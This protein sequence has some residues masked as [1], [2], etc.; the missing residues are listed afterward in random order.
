V[1][2]SDRERAD[3][4]LRAPVRLNDLG[5]VFDDTVASSAEVHVE[6]RNFYP[7]ML[8][9]ISSATSS[10]HINQFGF[11]PGSI[12]DQF[13]EVLSSKASDGIPVR[14]VVDRQGS[15]P[16]RGSRAFYERLLAAGIDVRVVRATQLRAPVQPVVVG[17]PTRWNFDRLGHIDH[18]KLVVVDGRVGWVGG[19]GIEDHFHDGRFHDLFLRVAGPVTSQLQLVFVATF[20][21]LGGVIPL[22]ELDL[23]F[24]A[25]E[26][27]PTAVPATVLHNAP[28][29]YRPITSAIADLLDGARESIDVVNPYVTDRRMIRRIAHAARRGVRVRLFVP[30]TANNW[31]CAAAQHHHHR[32]LLEAGVR[33]LEYPTMLHAKA[34]VRDGEDVL[35]GTCNLEAW[36]LK[37]FFE[38]DVLVRSPEV[39]RQF[40]ERFSA[41]AEVVST[42]GRALETR[43]ERV[44]GRVFATISPLL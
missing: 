37:R 2:V 21:W 22:N 13:A 17:G 44:K 41:P 34:I 33:I 24:P 43:R 18:R 6:G 8:Q 20:R 3:R 32:A 35:A 27:G 28:G 31:A 9:D 10:I 5:L 29:G 12:G 38:I 26:E 25:H 23:L 14:V 7:P 39:A 15:D 40:D 11:R 4:L 1:E 36:S 19:A 16:D 30:A 42:P